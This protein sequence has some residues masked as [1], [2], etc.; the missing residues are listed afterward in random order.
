MQSSSTQT[1][2]RSGLFLRKVRSLRVADRRRRF[3]F[4]MER[5]QSVGRLFLQQCNFVILAARQ[6]ESLMVSRAAVY[7][8]L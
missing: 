7:H 6:P 1:V 2:G 8:V 3:Q 4:C 5:F